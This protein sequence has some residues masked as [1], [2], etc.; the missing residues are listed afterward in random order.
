MLKA[1]ALLNKTSPP[2]RL[3][4]R[5][6]KKVYRT[7]INKAGSLSTITTVTV[8]AIVRPRQAHGLPKNECRLPKLYRCLAAHLHVFLYS[9]L[10]RIR[11][12]IIKV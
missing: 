6:I 3:V 10:S 8:W 9:V 2:P 5:E 7:A 12:R 1:K 4:T 11:D